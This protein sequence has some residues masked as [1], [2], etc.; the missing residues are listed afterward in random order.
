MREL[1]PEAE[2]LL[3]SLLLFC[4]FF[5]KLR[6]GKE[7]SLPSPIDRECHFITLSK[8][9]TKCVNHTSNR[10]MINIPPRHGKTELIIHFI[11]WSLARYP[12]SNFLYVSYG[13]K[14]ASKQTQIIRQI[15]NMHE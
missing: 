6:T 11:A 9:L 3:G 5:Y 12:D 13:H 14:L 7:F 8:E 2:K 1:T 10:L 4:K 15:V